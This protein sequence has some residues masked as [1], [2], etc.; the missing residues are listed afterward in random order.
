[1][2]ALSWV[3]ARGTYVTALRGVTMGPS[4]TA[5]AFDRCHGRDGGDVYS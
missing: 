3:V 2:M 5:R 1:M 4:V